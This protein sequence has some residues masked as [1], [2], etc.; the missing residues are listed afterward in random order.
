[1]QFGRR[2]GRRLIIQNQSPTHDLLLADTLL[3]FY[4]GNFK[5]H[6]NL[7]ESTENF[8]LNR[9]GGVS[10]SHTGRTGTPLFLCPHVTQ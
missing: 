2:N 1:M 9:K 7:I 8:I 10:H 4:G 5:W 3:H 6:F